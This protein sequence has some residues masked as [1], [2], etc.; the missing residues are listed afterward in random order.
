MD[1]DAG[2]FAVFAAIGAGFG[3]VGTVGVAVFAG[4]GVR[5]CRGFGRIT[6]VF[7]GVRIDT[8]AIGAGQA[9]WAV[10][11]DEVTVVATNLETSVRTAPLET[12]EAGHAGGL[13][14]VVNAVATATDLVGAAFDVGAP[15]AADT[16]L[17]RGCRRALTLVF[18]T[19][20][21]T[22]RTDAVSACFSIIARDQAPPDAVGTDLVRAV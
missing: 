22:V 16:D 7:G 20:G 4:V 11:G 5:A 1:G 19:G 3:D 9:G 13:A 6:F 2:A 12:D 17:V 18:D 14:L 15:V 8:F 21:C 10:F